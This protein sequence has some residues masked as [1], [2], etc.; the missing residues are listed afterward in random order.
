M[1]L[2]TLREILAGCA[3]QGWAVPGFDVI[4]LETVEA[5]LESATAERAPAIIMIYPNRTPRQWWPGLAALVRAEAAR[6]DLPVCLHLDHGRDLEQIQ[7]ALDLGFSSV[8][9]DGST[10]PLEENIALTRQVVETAHARG[11]SVE[12]ELGHVGRGDEDL[13]AAEQARRL[14]RV[15]EARQFVKA[16][17]VDALA[18]AIGTVHGLYRG[19]PELDFERLHALRK[20]INVPLVLHGGSG[21]PDEDIRQAVAGGI[22]KINVWT[23]LEHAFVGTL[24]EQLAGPVESCGLPEAMIAA[25]DSVKAVMRHKIAAGRVG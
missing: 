12:A 25:A 9:I 5:A 1:A 2:V 17:E 11:A 16:T 7:A 13:D 19:K 24:K 21:T 22:C 10:L 3:D 20:A 8:M 6:T 14:T 4:G 15:E 23:E 18:I